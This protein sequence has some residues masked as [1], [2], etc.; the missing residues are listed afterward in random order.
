MS[1]RST[2]FV[3]ITL[4]GIFGSSGLAGANDAPSTKTH[5]VAIRGMLFVPAKLVVHPGDRVR[6]TNED[7][8]PHTATATN[9]GFDS[10]TIAAGASFE[11]VVTGKGELPYGCLV[12]PSMK[13]MITIR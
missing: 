8:V 6:W 5:A 13:G 1:R 3:G 2:I 11:W 10:S 4:L 7:L 12:H 9:K